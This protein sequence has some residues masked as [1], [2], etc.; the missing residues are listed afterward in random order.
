IIILDY[1]YTSARES[2]NRRARQPGWPNLSGCEK[3]VFDGVEKA[4]ECLLPFFRSLVGAGGD[5]PA[6]AFNQFGAKTTVQAPGQLRPAQERARSRTFQTAWT[7]R[8]HEH[9][10][11][12]CARRC[13]D[14]GR[15]AGPS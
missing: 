8:V 10:P 3:I 13:A 11:P 6:D 2:A 9:P 4:I 14:T 1:Y 5:L 7:V 15:L 12:A